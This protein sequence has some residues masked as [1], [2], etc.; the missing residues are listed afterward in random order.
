VKFDTGFTW[1]TTNFRGIPGTVGKYLIGC[2]AG[3]DTSSTSLVNAFVYL[4]KNGASQA[5][6]ELDLSGNVF[7][8]GGLG[9]TTILDLGA[10]DY[11]E[12]FVYFD[13]NSTSAT[14]RQIDS[15][16]CVTYMFGTKLIG[17]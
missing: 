5:W 11:V 8:N 6:W 7:D 14:L 17:A 10:T 2:F 9:G 3:L 4:Y 13:F 16:Q 12:M 15:T 1:D